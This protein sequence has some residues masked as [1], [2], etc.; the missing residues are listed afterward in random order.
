MI[1]MFAK[2]KNFG[3]LWSPLVRIHFCKHNFHF[4]ESWRQ[5]IWLFILL[6]LPYEIY[7]SKMDSSQYWSWKKWI[8]FCHFEILTVWGSG[9][10]FGIS[11]ILGL[12]RWYVFL[13]KV[14]PSPPIYPNQPL[15]D[16][17]TLFNGELW[18]CRHPNSKFTLARNTYNTFIVNLQI[19]YFNLHKKCWG[20]VNIC[21]R[22]LTAK[23]TKTVNSVDNSFPMTLHILNQL[24]WKTK[25]VKRWWICIL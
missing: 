7:V 13:H 18:H 14:T 16:E 5:L 12:G 2:V 4:Y 6:I 24:L 23:V 1:S 15:I 10:D 8:P 19:Y 9:G 22:K 25:T 17:T 11:E 3:S 20:K 21:Y